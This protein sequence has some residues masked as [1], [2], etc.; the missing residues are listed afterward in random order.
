MW[1]RYGQ[2]YSCQMILM[3]HLKTFLNKGPNS[4]RPILFIFQFS[5]SLYTPPNK[6]RHTCP[7]LHVSGLWFVDTNFFLASINACTLVQIIPSLILIDQL[8]SSN[9]WNQ[10]LPI[11]QSWK[12]TIPLTNRWHWLTYFFNKSR[13]C[14]SE[15]V[16]NIALTL[17]TWFSVSLCWP[18]VVS[19]FRTGVGELRLVSPN[20]FVKPLTEHVGVFKSWTETNQ[21]WKTLQVE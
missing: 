16:G 7:F 18:R 13:I 21:S 14:V 8:S 3:N 1:G 20:R 9:N 12:S 19:K 5:I 10:F 11:R 17:L 6:S 15:T 4:T 2:I